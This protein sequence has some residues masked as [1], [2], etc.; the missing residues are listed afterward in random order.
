MVNAVD[1]PS[2]GHWKERDHPKK[3]NPKINPDGEVKPSNHCSSPGRN[4]KCNSYQNYAWAPTEGVAD[5]S[6]RRSSKELDNGQCKPSND[7]YLRHIDDRPAAWHRVHSCGTIRGMAVGIVL[8]KRVQIHVVSAWGR[9]CI[10]E[11]GQCV[12]KPHRTNSS[13]DVRQTPWSI[14]LRVREAL[15]LLVS[16]APDQELRNHECETMWQE[17]RGGDRQEF[18]LPSLPKSF[19]QR[20]PP[21]RMLP[22]IRCPP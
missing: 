12:D 17:D 4:C 11:H 18:A 13:S 16:V 1:I 9:H 8:C 10:N 14:L 22:G 2:E 20:S 7:L 19:S 21:S 5:G 15:G 6:Q 3:A